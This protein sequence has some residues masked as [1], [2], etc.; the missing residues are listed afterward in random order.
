[1]ETTYFKFINGELYCEGVPIA[2]LA[3]QIK[4]PFY[5]YSAGALAAS[6]TD[7]Q[8][9]FSQID[10]LICFAMKS[11]SNVA[12]IRSFV[13]LGAGVDVV[14]GGELLRALWAGADPKKIVFSGVGKTRDE[15]ALALEK[16]ILQFNVESVAELYALQ[17]VAHSLGK[18]A[19]IALRVNPNVDPKTHPYI[20][21]GLKKNK[22]G[23]PWADVRAVYQEAKALS[24]IDIQAVS[25]HIGSQLTDISPFVDSLKKLRELVLALRE[26][27][28]T[29]SRID[30][31]G[32]LGIVYQDEV[33]PSKAQYAAAI[34]PIIRELGV[35]LMLEPGRSLAGNAGILVTKVLYTKPGPEKTFVIVDAAMN[36]LMRPALYGAYQAIQPVIQ[37]QT[38]ERLATDIVGP[39]CET[40]DFLAK[41]RPLPP[42][43]DDDLLAVM[44]AGAYGSA[45]SSTYN[46]RPLI[47]EVMVKGDHH[48]IIREPGRVEDL[49]KGESIPEFL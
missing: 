49:V 39:V 48:A 38:A 28:I 15:L 7:Y 19:P 40:G 18:Q 37:K 26:D 43:A 34:V 4:T 36:D 35:K 3:N 9:A 14:S 11:N 5:L 22:F 16:E 45:M 31:G 27:G 46:S 42:L 41:D 12:V 6:F 10:P 32:G 47:A 2:T 23:I 20:S 25:C 8:H 17:D 44:S 24:H 30:L 13:R 21:T 33:P 29:L 1:M